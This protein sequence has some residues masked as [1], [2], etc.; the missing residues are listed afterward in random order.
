[1]HLHPGSASTVSPR[2]SALDSSSTQ[3]SALDTGSGDGN[4]CQHCRHY[5]SLRLGWHV[6]WPIELE[7]HA[8]LQHFLRSMRPGA[9]AAVWRPA[10]RTLAA[11]ATAVQWSVGQPCNHEHHQ[12]RPQ[13]ARLYRNSGWQTVAWPTSDAHSS[14]AWCRREVPLHFLSAV[15]GPWFTMQP[16]PRMPST[17]LS[18]PRRSASPTL[19]SFT[20]VDSAG[21]CRHSVTGSS[22]I[23]RCHYECHTPHRRSPQNAHSMN[24]R[25][26][27]ETTAT[28]LRCSIR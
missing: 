5:P 2:G 8:A 23:S 3:G 9:E 21:R 14:T 1:M 12:Q 13:M 27:R 24:A 16:Y 15:D 26:P 20:P 25:S 17:R 6:P 4:R 19:R 18:W 7:V 28:A 22:C 10:Y 11:T